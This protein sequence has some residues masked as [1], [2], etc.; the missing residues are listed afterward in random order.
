MIS[1]KLFEGLFKF[2]FVSSHALS[3]VHY[4][5]DREANKDTMSEEVTELIQGVEQ[6]KVTRDT[7]SKGMCTDIVST[8]VE[9]CFE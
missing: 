6:K 1:N 2:Y 5:E 7:Q 8:M 4:I 3:N 9:L